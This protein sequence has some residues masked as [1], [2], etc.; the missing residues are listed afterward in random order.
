MEIKLGWSNYI[1]TLLYYRVIFMYQVSQKSARLCTDLP[2]C[3]RTLFWDTLYVLIIQCIYST[4]CGWLISVCRN[5][6]GHFHLVECNSNKIKEKLWLLYINPWR[7]HTKPTPRL[8]LPMS[9][10]LKHCKILLAFKNTLLFLSKLWIVSRYW[11]VPL[12]YSITQSLSTI[13]PTRN[14]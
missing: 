9:I 1:F 6:Y 11:L 13:S 10:T 14:R 2:S 3:K 7:N 4:Y 8:F 5:I 12:T